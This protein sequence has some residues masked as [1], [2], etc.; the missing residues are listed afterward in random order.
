[1]TD[2]FATR[3][4]ELVC[5][6]RDWLYAMLAVAVAAMLINLFAYPHIGGHRPTRVIWEFNVVILVVAI[7]CSLGG[8]Y[9]CSRL[10]E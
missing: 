3:F 9:A 1:M 5:G 10:D 8:L 6:F 2:R 4:L 7:S